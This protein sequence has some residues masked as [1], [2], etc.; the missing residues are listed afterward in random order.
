VHYTTPKAFKPLKAFNWGTGSRANKTL[1]S[2]IGKCPGE[3]REKKTPGD[4]QKKRSQ[5]NPLLQ[6]GVSG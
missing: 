4:A 5:N 1:L 6:N 3:R 2:D